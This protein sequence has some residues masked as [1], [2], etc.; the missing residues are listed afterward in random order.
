VARGL[1]ID[2]GFNREQIG[3]LMD[4]AGELSYFLNIDEGALFVGQPVRKGRYPPLTEIKY[5]T[6][7]PD[8]N[9]ADDIPLDSAKQFLWEHEDENSG[10]D[11]DAQEDFQGRAE[12]GRSPRGIR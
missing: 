6:P 11:E 7:M 1:Y 10:Q 2:A 12:G 5:M 8:I 9:T 3:A 4:R